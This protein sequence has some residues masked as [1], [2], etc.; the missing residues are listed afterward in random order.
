MGKKPTKRE[1][2]V[3]F[4]PDYLALVRPV[5]EGRRARPTVTSVASVKQNPWPDHNVFLAAKRRRLVDWA[6]AD[7]SPSAAESVAEYART[8]KRSALAT[9]T[10]H[11]LDLL[12]NKNIELGTRLNL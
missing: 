9:L 4:C 11:E 3:F 6:H 1:L 7:L 5:P 12:K 10:K 8:C 2:E